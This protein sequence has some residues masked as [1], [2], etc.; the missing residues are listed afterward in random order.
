MCALLR[1]AASSPHFVLPFL[2]CAA[3]RDDAAALRRL[4]DAGGKV[5]EKDAVRSVK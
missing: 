3:K 1:A 4:L 5:D 2:H